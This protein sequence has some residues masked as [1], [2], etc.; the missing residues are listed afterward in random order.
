MVSE[1]KGLRR[2]LASNQRSS[3]REVEKS[4]RATVPG[5]RYVCA[6]TPT[7]GFE[8]RAIATDREPTRGR[9]L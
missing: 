8:A 7:T 5:P 9:S 2:I 6:V 3:C 4:F 1:N